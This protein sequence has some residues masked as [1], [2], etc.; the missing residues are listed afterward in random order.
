MSGGRCLA[1]AAI[2]ALEENSSV[3]SPAPWRMSD[4][5][6]RTLASASTTK[7]SGGRIASARPGTFTIASDGSGN[8]G[9]GLLAITLEPWRDRAGLGRTDLVALN[10][11][12]ASKL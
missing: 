5:N 4:R 10:T 1:A 12:Q 6:R 3:C 11:M 8:D 2:A 7:Q 9:A